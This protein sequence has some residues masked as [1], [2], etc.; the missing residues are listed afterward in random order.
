MFEAL[1]ANRM[2]C[3]AGESAFQVLAAANKLEAAGKKVIHFEI[4]EPDFATAKNIVEAGK[5]ALDQGY[6][7]Y[8]QS[9]GIIS[10]REAIVAYTKKYKGIDCKKEEVVVAPGGK[11]IIFYTICVL[12]NPG[13]E[14]ICPNPGFPTYE[15]VVRYAGGI[16]VPVNLAEKSSFRLD[17]EELKAKIT[18]RTKLLILNSPSNPTGSFLRP[19]DLKEISQ[20]VKDKNIFILSDEI[21]SRIVYEGRTESIASFP[22]MKDKTIIL[23]GFSK[24][25]AMTGWRLGYGIMH[26]DIAA[27]MTQLLI[28]SNS[29][30][31]HFVQMAGVEAINGPQDGVD[32]MVKEFKHRR[33]VIVNGLNS[34]KGIRCLKPDGAFYAFP[35]VTE[36][37]L[38]SGDL[39][40]YLL[41][42]AGVALL[43]GASFGRAGAGYLRLSYASSL[44]LIYA[45]LER[46]EAAIKKLA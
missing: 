12:V 5:R 7:T 24:T 1:L 31:A 43:D 11:P 37:G 18:P 21:Y 40:R 10:L 33:D 14:V 39:A 6:T 22:G 44:D 27:K 34:I 19:E 20:A 46:I 4:G 23:D 25:Y 45:G 17:V 42:E 29:C 26:E 35:N 41:Q 32:A 38:K 13:D 36:T 9:Q 3:L 15:S 28:N 30:T 16:P 8:C 2:N